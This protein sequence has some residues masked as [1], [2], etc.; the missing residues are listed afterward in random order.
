[1]TWTPEQD[2]MLTDLVK[3]G[4][5]PY[6]EAAAAINARFKT[7][8]SRNA[9]IGRGKRIGLATPRK[10]VIRTTKPAKAQSKPRPD[11]QARK[12]A[13]GPKP[14]PPFVAR[15]ADVRP[16]NVDLV[17]LAPDGCRWAY[18]DGPFVFCNHPRVWG[19]SYCPAHSHLAYRVMERRA[20]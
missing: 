9:A 1:M 11:I 2:A 17:D 8:F 6:S 4:G 10:I 19:L 20:A 18:G 3:T 12:A 16:G 15:I 5:E 13:S 14:P 7:R